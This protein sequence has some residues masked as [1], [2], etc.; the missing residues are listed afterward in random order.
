M[1]KTFGD[2]SYSYSVNITPRSTFALE[3]LLIFCLILL[4]RYGIRYI[5]F[6]SRLRSIKE[7][8]VVVPEY[9]APPQIPPA[10]FDVL[11]D[12][13]A[14]IRSIGATFLSL[15]L[16]GYVN[17]EYNPGK[18][19]FYI[20]RTANEVPD[21]LYQHEKLLLRLFAEQPGL[22]ASTLREQS[23]IIY[24]EF[25]FAVLRDLQHA[26]YY[27]FHKNMDT[28]GPL[29]YYVSV[30]LQAFV[31][32][33]TK[34]WNWPGFALSI[35]FPL[36]GVAWIIASLIFYNR[37]GIYNYRT[38]AWEKIWPE[39]AGYY[40]YLRIVE[41]KKRAFALRDTANFKIEE[42][43]PYLVAALLQNGWDHVFAASSEIGAGGSEYNTM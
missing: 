35:L 33:I 31:R 25:N 9:V 43:D 11:L 39:V 5:L 12:N 8:N 14:S 15:S 26:G 6:R 21:S 40:N 23:T 2:V 3:C 10:F 27:K 4:G 28:I 41:S 13:R 18:Q 37:I 29:Q 30:T 7:R 38:S 20:K 32:G 22:W 19:D 24:A 16:K 1:Y 17:I 34:P 36:L 42:H